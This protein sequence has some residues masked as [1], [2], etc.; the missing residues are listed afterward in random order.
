MV[1]FCVNID[2]GFIEKKEF[3][4]VLSNVLENIQAYTQIKSG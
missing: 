3:L 1:G 4:E 2:S